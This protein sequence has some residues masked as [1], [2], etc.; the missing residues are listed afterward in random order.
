MRGRCSVRI[1]TDT[2][3]KWQKENDRLVLQSQNCNHLDRVK[4]EVQ[5]LDLEEKEYKM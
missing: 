4:G 3:Q 1:L 5:W 2:I